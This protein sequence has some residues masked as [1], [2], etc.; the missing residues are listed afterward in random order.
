M[1]TPARRDSR[2]LRYVDVRQ[3]L[4]RRGFAAPEPFGLFVARHNPRLLRFEHVPRLAAIVDR[5]IS[6]AV[7]RLL[8]IL[9]PRYFKTEI[10]SR[11]LGGYFARQ[12]PHQWAA[13]VSYGADLAWEISEDARHYYLGDGGKLD[14]DSGAKKRWRTKVGGGCWAA[15]VGGPLLGRGYHL[16]IVDDP[17]DPEKAHSPTYQR[18][19]REWWPAKFLSRQEP[20]ARII[21]VMQR[22][23][24]EDPVDFLFRREVGEDTELAPEHWHVALLDEIKSSEPLGRWGG[25]MGLPPTCTLEPDPRPHGAVLA[26]TRFTLEQA[27]QLQI[28]AG[29]IVASAQRQGRPIRPAGDF[30]RK[31]WFQIYDELPEHAHNGGKDW[32]TAYTREEQNS[33]SAWIESYRGVDRTGPDGKQISGTFPIYVHDCGWDWWEF[34][35]LVAE[36]LKLSGPHFIEKKASGKSAAQTLRREKIRVEE[37]AVD[38]DKLA[39]ASGVQPVV[40]QGRIYVRRSIVTRLFEGERQG[41]LRVT[42]EGLVTGTGDLDLNDAF[43]QAIARHTGWKKRKVMVYYPGMAAQQEAET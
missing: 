25:P 30:W 5:V 11:L 10:F 1:P 35:E 9:P 43:V 42:A 37:V 22:L 29:P 13:I 8:V 14:P 2:R 6:G 31:D 23:G 39:R 27:R 21:V 3:E 33:A 28:V 36:M 40:A 26:P 34:P 17:T 4:Q 15:G 16:G 12:N 20:G 18:R 7:P 19:F 32:D 41:L 38:G 24:V